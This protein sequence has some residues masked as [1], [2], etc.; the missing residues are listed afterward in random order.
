MSQH[1]F[2]RS[3][4][5][6]LA[7]TALALTTGVLSAATVQTFSP[8]GEVAKVRQAR[9]TFTE[10][11]VRFG[12][13]KLPSPF[14]LACLNST[15]PAGSG[16]WVD[17]KTW[18]HDFTQDV[19]AGTK[20]SFK[21][22]SGLKTLAGD[23]VQGPAAY[24]FSTGGP[25]IVRAYPVAGEG[26]RIE[27]EQVF[28]L[29]L[30]GA[31][32]AASIERH[33]R[34]EVAGLG[35]QLPLKVVTGAVRDAILKA[36]DLLPQQARVA[37]V[38]CARPLP[39]DAR[40]QVVWARGI[41]T[42]SGVP[43]SNDRTLDYAVRPPFSAS[44]TCERTSSRADCLPIRPMRIEF[45]SPV[46]RKLAERIVLIAPDG[47][48]KPE[49]EQQRGETKEQLLSVVRNGI[50]QF[51]YLFSRKKGEVGIDPSDSGVSA[52]EFKGPLPESA[53]IR[54]ELPAD[55]RDDAGR[56]LSNASA[57]PLKTR[58]A[59]APALAKFPAAT[60]GILELNAEPMLPLTVRRIE[61]DLKVKGLATPGSAVRDLKLADDQ[62]IIDWLAKVKRY[63]EG[64]LPRDEVQSELGIKLPPPV[65]KAKPARP[66]KRYGEAVPEDE[67]DDNADRPDVVQTRTV[68]LLN[69]E[70][71]AKKL[72]LP[73][74]DAK[75]D[76]RPFE[77]IGIPM[78]QPGFHVVEVESAKLGQA[79]LDR[80]APMFVRTSVLVTNL[81][82]HF[83]TSTN[84]SLVWVTT[85][86]KGKPVEAAQVQISDCQGQVVW[87]GRTDKLGLAMVKKELPRLT[88]EYCQSGASRNENETGYFVSARKTDAHGRADMA[89]VWSTWNQGIEPWRFHVNTSW[90][91]VPSPSIYHSVL[92]RTLLRAGQTVSMQH[93]ARLEKLTGLGLVDPRELPPTLTIVHEGT[94]QEFSQALS[95]RGRHA[96]SSFA[97]PED[98]KLGVYNIQLVRDGQRVSTGSFRVEEFRLPVMTGRIIPPKA[99]LIQPK[100]VSLGLQINYGN[101][102]GAAGLPVRVSA[103]W[104]DA[105]LESALR[106]ERYPGFRFNPPREPRDPNAKSFF[107]E[108]Y[109]DEGDEESSVYTPE[110]RAKLVADKLPVTLDKNGAGNVLLPK[111]PATKVPRE[112]LV[113][114]TYADPNGEVQTLSQTVPVWPAGL[115]LGVRTE[116]WVSVKQKVATQV[117]VL[118]TAGQPKAGVSV[119]VRAVAHRTNSTRKR[120]VGGFYAYDNQ[121]AD[122]DLG[123][124]CS[125]TSDA[126][127][128][129]LC[130]GTLK[131]AGEVELIAQANDAAGNTARSAASVWVTRQG[132]L[133]FGGENQDRMDV[134]PEQR[135][136]EPGQTAKFQV[137]SPFRHATA[138]VAIERNGII[139]TRTLELNG[140]DPTISLDVKAE[141]GPN[142]FVSVLAVRGRVHEVPWYSFFTWG[143]RSPTEWWK[144]F[145]DDGRDYQMPTAMVDLSKPAF[146]Y[147]IAE[148]EVGTAGHRLKVEVQPDKARYPIRATSQ[149]RVKVSLPNGQ[150]A[151]AGTEV[152]LAAVDEALLELSPNDSWDLLGAMVRKRGYGVDTATAQMQI[153]G[154]RHFGKKAA[155][156]GG[157]GGQFPTRELF[158]TLLLWNPRVVLDAK[159][160]AVVKVPLNDSLTSFRIV[161]IADAVQGANAGLFG[162]GRASIAATQDLQIVSGVPPLVREGDRYRAMFTLRNTTAQAM[163]ASFTAQVGTDTLP[164]QRIRIEPN[165]AAEAG[166]DV[167]VPF[168]VKQQEWTVSAESGAVR[169]RMKVTQKVAEAVPVTVQQATLM[170]LDKGS[171][172]IPIGM[173]ATA[174]ADAQGVPRGGI[175]VAFKPKL[176][177]GLPGVR[178]FFERYLWDCL[179]QRA[180]IAIGLRD[181]EAWRSLASRIPLYL[182]DDGLAHYFPPSAS[183]G[184]TG[185]DSLTA[186]LLAISDEAS[187]L[188]Y[189]FSLPDDTRLRM[190]RGLAAFVE[191]RI[192]RDFWVPAFLKN[193]DLDVRKLAAIEA[194]SRTGKV[195]ARMLDSVQILPN[196]WPTSAVIDWLSI[197][198]RVKDIPE[199]DKRMLEAE[200]IL[201]ARL[202][203][204]GTRLGFST[205]RDDS[206]WWLMANGDVN[207]VRMILAT[208]P[209]AAWKDDLPRLVTG[210]LQRQQRG[211]W[212][213]TVSNAWGSVAIEA[214]SK[215]FERDPVTGTS[216]VGFE[217]GPAPQ[218]FSWSQSPDGGK[219]ALGWPKP[220]AG[221]ASSPAGSNVKVTHE[222]TGKPWLT[223]TSKA[224][225]RLTT[226]FSSGYRITKTITPVEQKVKGQYS[227]GDVLR[228]HLQI[229]AQAD[230]T[231][232]VVNDPIPGGSTLLGSGLGRDDAMSTTDERQDSRGWLAYQERSF[233]AFRSY[234]RYLPKG[235]LVLE[236]TVRLNNPGTFGLPQTRVEAMYAPEMFGEFPNAPVAVGP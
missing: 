139:E 1:W 236:Y 168:N 64:R 113:Q 99:A 12:D 191:G 185:S 223:F 199:R 85:L 141:W 39:N 179:E 224:A 2:R 46:P 188:G 35:E 28:A 43:N 71:D 140:K 98:A 103:Q 36:V 7:W 95:W 8:Q 171:V 119:S 82:V 63:N 132:E 204:Q 178:D 73:S 165:A 134:I 68:S 183:S 144:A 136:Y 101:G 92:D 196:Q 222:G 129:V 83:K 207:S 125:G 130:E 148:I 143:W 216:K 176:S 190:E 18:V 117:V 220:V 158:D 27:E 77:V 102:G 213:T 52:V 122:E 116:E 229:D 6:A 138:L 226:P 208:L 177:D 215:R 194:L 93:H 162:T 206:W 211:R 91:D 111:L 44:F 133:W 186:Y 67:E 170:Q 72:S 51:F 201:R 34:C 42:P 24:D 47:Q 151:P 53:D 212:S 137:R 221:S 61:G 121:N 115:A 153:I 66:A 167:T 69:R 16:R 205:E 147:G 81:G 135:S 29:L 96:E 152:A 217:P 184:R 104:R 90:S 74:G 105:N 107:S 157:G 32:T 9:A 163:E 227:R 13:P 87:S 232:V 79:L 80:D 45:S 100:D 54:I 4:P 86:D 11:M 26:S 218:N 84:N 57:F 202:N 209:K 48:R 197:L 70:A 120:L 40:V 189:D 149:V 38:Q 145:N 127:G 19:P 3:M 25:T 235:P 233:E 181:V 33:G 146:K 228:V 108:D 17:D 150:P 41:A 160:E 195:Q 155:P 60:F 89:F 106:T 159:G 56:V 62:A 142:V 114:A 110:E 94:G 182:D 172:S 76:A 187:K 169:D 58:T 175:E 22:K 128:L 123:Q 109:V 173:P 156:P 234:Y 65:K 118:D 198:D 225:I 88:W 14:D 231:W 23:A 126:R 75:V 203:V 154:K 50:R 200:Q 30:T 31:A 59:E 180:S 37:T 219:V 112:M 131:S 193:G 192:K 78:N 49:V 166:W 21:L 230:M 174:L 15:P 164:A 55:L 5:K 161:V 10:S 97:I 214:F 20:C 210:T 124:V